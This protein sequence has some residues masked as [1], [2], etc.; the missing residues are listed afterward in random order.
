V[1]ALLGLTKIDTSLVLGAVLILFVLLVPSGFIPTV[2]KLLP[3]RRGA[4]A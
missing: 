2:R 3:Q 1:A 4:T